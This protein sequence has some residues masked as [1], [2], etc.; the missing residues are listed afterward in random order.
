MLCDQ[1]RLTEDDKK[2]HVSYETA[3]KILK[4]DFISI[5][6]C[7]I[8]GGQIL[9]VICF[10]IQFP[11]D[12]NITVF[13]RVEHC[14]EIFCLLLG[15]LQLCDLLY[16][17]L[18]LSVCESFLVEHVV[19]KIVNV[20]EEVLQKIE[21][22][23]AASVSSQL[24]IFLIEPKL[25]LPSPIHSTGWISKWLCVSVCVSVSQSVPT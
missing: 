16:G 15:Y 8:I 13:I 12:I 5:T 17:V 10:D 3:K 18:E 21:A 20:A 14:E 1:K 2:N 22:V 4:A 24:I 6:G 11:L 19:L 25:F 9:F 7:L 23:S